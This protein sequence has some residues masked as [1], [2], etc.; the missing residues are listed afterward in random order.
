MC[1][2]GGCKINTDQPFRYSIHFGSTYHVTLTQGDNKFEFDSCNDSGYL[3]R[4]DAALENGMVLIMSHWGTTYNTMKW[5][6][7]MTGC[8]GDCDTS[9]Q[10]IFSDISIS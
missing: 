5:L 9:G 1:P 3:Q 6:D 10:F 8:N 4:M 7:D 2:G